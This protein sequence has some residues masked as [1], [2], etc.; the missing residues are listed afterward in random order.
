MYLALEMHSHGTVA[1]R[2]TIFAC[3]SS[4]RAF[5]SAVSA[6]NAN[7]IPSIILTSIAGGSCVSARFAAHRCAGGRL[8]RFQQ[9]LVAF[10]AAAVASSVF[11]GLLPPEHAVRAVQHGV[12][13]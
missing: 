3:R 1:R 4:Y 5:S 6:R 12:S 10:T 11:A 2:A 8:H 13:V 7:N 9:C